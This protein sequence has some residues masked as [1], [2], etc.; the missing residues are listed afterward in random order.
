MYGALYD[1]GPGKQGRLAM[2]AL[3]YTAAIPVLTL[4]VSSYYLIRDDVLGF[5]KHAEEEEK[6]KQ[7]QQNKVDDKE[8]TQKLDN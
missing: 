2:G 7:L 6:K 3:M 5:E 4:S 8:E 1:S